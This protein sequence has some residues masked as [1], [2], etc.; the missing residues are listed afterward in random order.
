MS[1]RAAMTPGEARALIREAINA[2][3]ALRDEASFALEQMRGR[4]WDFTTDETEAQLNGVFRQASDVIAKQ[5]GYL[6]SVSDLD[7]A[8]LAS[9]LNDLAPNHATG[10]AMIAGLPIVR[11]LDTL[12]SAA[13][14]LTPIVGEAQSAS[15][16][17]YFRDTMTK[18]GRAVGEAAGTAVGA[19]G[20]A[21]LGAATGGASSL[22]SSPGGVLVALVVAYLLWRQA[23]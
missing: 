14:S 18:V 4:F 20:D 3:Y 1:A 22:L 17:A 16:T 2:A 7:D 21:A 5:A 12:R 19:V 13:S 15:F 10:E 11:S 23:K 8:G 9:I 6:Q